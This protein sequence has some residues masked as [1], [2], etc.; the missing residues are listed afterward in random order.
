QAQSQTS[1]SERISENGLLKTSQ[2]SGDIF[3]VD[4]RA[5]G[6]QYKRET[7]WGVFFEEANRAVARLAASSEDAIEADTYPYLVAFY[8][9]LTDEAFRDAFLEANPSI[10][11]FG[12]QEALE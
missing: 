8:R 9:A 7:D 6:V 12:A 11:P 2:V 4:S 3:E 5:E 10:E 1:V